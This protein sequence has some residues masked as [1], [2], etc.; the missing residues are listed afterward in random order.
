VCVHRHHEKSSQ[1]KFTNKSLS[2]I[3]SLEKALIHLGFKPAIVY[4]KK[5]DIYNIYL[6]T[7][8]VKKYFE[9]IG[10]N[11]PKNNIKFQKWLEN[12]VMPLNSE[13]KHIISLEI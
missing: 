3:N 1:L 10:S 9:E 13:I 11:N 4:N 2:L 8:D 12:G 7:E 6:F 5:R